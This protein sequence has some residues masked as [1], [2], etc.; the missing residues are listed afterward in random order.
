MTPTVLAFGFPGSWEWI[1]ILGVALVAA[2]RARD[3]MLR[4]SQ[5]GHHMVGGA[6]AAIEAHVDDQAL[7]AVTGMVEVLLHLQ[8]ARHVHASDVQIA[9]A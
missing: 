6:A 7:L 5:R 1:A 2:A 8:E 3:R 4:L 9:E